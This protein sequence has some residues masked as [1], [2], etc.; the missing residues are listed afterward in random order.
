MQEARP[1]HRQETQFM[2]KVVKSS[3]STLALLALIFQTTVAF[4]GPNKPTRDTP[5]YQE[6]DNFVNG[7]D[8]PIYDDYRD[9]GSARDWDSPSEGDTSYGPLFYEPQF[10]AALAKEALNS[11]G[12][13]SQAFG[14]MSE[15]EKQ[16]LMQMT[17]LALTATAGGAGVYIASPY[18]KKALKSTHRVAIWRSAALRAIKK[19]AVAAPIIAAPALA[20]AT[21]LAGTVVVLATAAD[22]LKPQATN[23][24]ETLEYHLTQE[25]FEAWLNGSDDLA[26]LSVRMHPEFSVFVLEMTNQLSAN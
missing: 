4:A 16:E 23:V 10:K 24:T 3:V 9:R 8:G 22:A 19:L 25:G 1:S 14:S 21:P 26:D 11:R 17:A 15:T 18:L 13:L 20:A 2:L 6:D 5:D 7:P 12:F